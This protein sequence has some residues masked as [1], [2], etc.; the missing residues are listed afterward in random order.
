MQILKLDRSG[1]ASLT[2]LETPSLRVRVRKAGL[3]ST[4]PIF[5]VSADFVDGGQ[6][7]YLSDQ[8][9]TSVFVDI[10]DLR[11]LRRLDAS[12]QAD[13]STLLGSI[14]GKEPLWLADLAGGRLL[15]LDLRPKQLTN[16]ACALAGRALTPDEWARLIGA[17]RPY[18]PR[19]QR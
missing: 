6:R 13:N 14:D 18:L 16:W 15:S 9:G 17:D 5:P 2:L 7:L 10:W 1:G 8:M 3:S 12:W 19:C 11:S 4:N